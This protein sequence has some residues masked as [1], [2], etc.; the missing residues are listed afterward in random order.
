MITLAALGQM[1]ITI[2]IG[3][4]ILAIIN[5][6][7]NRNERRQNVENKKAE[8]ATVKAEAE[9]LLS[10]GTLEWAQAVRSDNAEVREQ[11]TKL[12]KRLD[13]EEDFVEQLEEFVRVLLRQVRE[14][15]IW[16]M[17]TVQELADNG[18]NVPPPPVLDPNIPLPQRRGVTE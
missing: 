2:G 6:Y 11:A 16:D 17:R 9:K 10:S 12:R 13:I 3:S 15:A 7:I 8:A 18:I 1:A 14:H 4:I 5:A